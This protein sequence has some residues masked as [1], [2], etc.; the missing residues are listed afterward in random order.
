MK[1][2][3]T[4]VCNQT[5]YGGGRHACPRRCRRRS[6]T[7]PLQHRHRPA[8]ISADAERLLTL[9]FPAHSHVI[10]SREAVRATPR[11]SP[12]STGGSCGPG[13]RR[14][15]LGAR[16]RMF[17][18]RRLQNIALRP[19]LCLWS[20]AVSGSKLVQSGVAPLPSGR[21]NNKFRPRGRRSRTSSSRLFRYST[22]LGCASRHGEVS[23]WS[24]ERDWK[25]RTC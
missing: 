1:P 25:S 23:E 3:S 14:G 5:T 9:A 13:S 20:G 12:L 21:S 10:E 6:C 7:T 24:K 15:K 17:E 22:R 19:Q 4:P 8:A 16:A 2:T 11:R 18:A